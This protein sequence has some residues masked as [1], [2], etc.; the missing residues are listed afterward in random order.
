MKNSSNYILLLASIFICVIIFEITL[1]FLGI[2]YNNNPLISSKILHHVHP[3]NYSFQAYLVDEPDVSHKIYYDENGLSSTPTNSV[4]KNIIKRIALMGDSFTEAIQVPYENSFCGILNNNPNNLVKNFGVS[5]YSP[6]FYLIQWNTIVRKFNPTHV[7]I[8]LY[9]ND[10]SSDERFFE[11]A[12]KDSSGN[13]ISIPGP[14]PNNIVRLARKSYFL[15]FCKKVVN[16]ISWIYNNHGKEKHI[17]GGYVEE[18]ISLSKATKENLIK[19][20]NAIELDNA[21]LIIMVIPS[22]FNLKDES[23]SKKKNEF[24]DEVKLFCEENQINFL[25]LVKLFNQDKI[26]TKINS[27]FNNDIHFNKHGHSIVGNALL[28]YLNK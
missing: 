9:D 22:K 27:F 12:K 17:A 1:R 21:Q 23:I 25:D 26:S 6:I 24:S 4:K 11:L 28:S 10:V 18:D 16:T 20:K 7:I 3:K 15:R 8:Q 2:G 14:D 5:S 13:L 19:I